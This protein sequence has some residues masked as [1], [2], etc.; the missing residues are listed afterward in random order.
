MRGHAFTLVNLVG[1]GIPGHDFIRI[2]VVRRDADTEI[3][4][5]GGELEFLTVTKCLFSRVLSA[6]YYLVW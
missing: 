6:H 5:I 4:C 3:L 2:I 1:I